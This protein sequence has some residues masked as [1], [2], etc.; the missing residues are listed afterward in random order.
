[1]FPRPRGP[2]LHPRPRGPKHTPRPRGPRTDDDIA[3]TIRRDLLQWSWV[4]R[5][6]RYRRLCLTSPNMARVVRLLTSPDQLL[7]G[8]STGVQP[9]EIICIRPALRVRQTTL[10][11]LWRLRETLA[12]AGFNAEI[13]AVPTAP[14]T[15]ET[16]CPATAEF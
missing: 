3:L 11:E 14:A 6:Q 10:T 5:H 12:V 7:Q 9:T 15:A 8:R 2:A 16:Q 4:K 13:E 1:M